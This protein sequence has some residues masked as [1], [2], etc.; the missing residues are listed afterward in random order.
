M[1]LAGAISGVG[2]AGC[3]AAG[4]LAS[5]RHA[6]WPAVRIF[7][8]LVLLTAAGLKAYQLATEPLLAA[9]RVSVPA[10][11]WLRGWVR[12]Q[13]PLLRGDSG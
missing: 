11:L 8:G 10:G 2:R 9:H 6:V 13:L 1:S 12:V 7:L 3:R 5:F 4:G